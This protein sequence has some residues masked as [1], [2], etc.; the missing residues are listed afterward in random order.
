M[1]TKPKSKIS[2]DGG[3]GGGAC[4]AD[5]IKSNPFLVALLSN[6]KQETVQQDSA[7]SISDNV[8]LNPHLHHPSFQKQKRSDDVAPPLTNS[9]IHNSSTDRRKPGSG[10]DLTNHSHNNPFRCAVSFREGVNVPAILPASTVINTNDIEQFPSLGVPG[11]QPLPTQSKVLDFKNII[12]KHVEAEGA[13]AGAGAGAGVGVSGGAGAGEESIKPTYSKP[14]SS[15]STSVRNLS[16][17]NIFLGAFYKTDDDSYNE[18]SEGNGVDDRDCD[19][20]SYEYKCSSITSI[21]VDRCD[22]AYDKLYK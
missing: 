15:V 7:K 10:H 2:R 12:S 1:N 13:G 3:G 22:S 18:T 21:L 11:K 6:S 14:V 16:K 17:G 5:V 9:F 20:S 19:T 4:S 8:F